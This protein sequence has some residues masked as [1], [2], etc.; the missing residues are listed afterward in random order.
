MMIRAMT[1]REQADEI[2]MVGRGK[3]SLYYIW[4]ASYDYS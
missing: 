2:G 1:K 3:E 4:V